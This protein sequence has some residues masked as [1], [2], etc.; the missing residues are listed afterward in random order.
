[1]HVIKRLSQSGADAK[2]WPGLIDAETLIGVDTLRSTC[3]GGHIF[4]LS[5]IFVPLG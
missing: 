4:W 2:P 5:G 3:M 1:M